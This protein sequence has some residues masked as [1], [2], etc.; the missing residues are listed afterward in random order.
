MVAGEL[1]HGSFDVAG[2]GLPMPLPKGE[3]SAVE[4]FADSVGAVIQFVTV[5]A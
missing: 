2:I 3:P 1:P 4:R 5:V